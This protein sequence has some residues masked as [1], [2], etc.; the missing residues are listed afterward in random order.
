MDRNRL[1][2][3]VGDQLNAILSTVGMNFHKL[4][5]WA[6]GFL[7]QIFCWLLSCQRA[8]TIVVCAEK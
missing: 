7:R 8:T 4:L 6:A 2:G 3:V 5:R 1:H